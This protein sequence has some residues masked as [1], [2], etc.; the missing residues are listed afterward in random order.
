MI[1]LRNVRKIVDQHSAIE[2]DELVVTAG[3][4]A[5]VVGPVNSGR[6][7]LFDLLTGRTRPTMGEVRVAG[8]TPATD[9]KALSRCAGILFTEDMLYARQSP[10][11]NLTFYARLYGLPR[12]RA[13]D[14]LD[15]VGLAEQAKMK[16]DKMSPGMLRRLA[17]GRAI[18]HDPAALILAEPFAQCDEMSVTMLSGAMRRLAEAGKA[19]LVVASD[20]SHLQALC[21]VIYLLDNGKIVSEVRPGEQ[22]RQEVPFKVPAR[23]ED[24]V[25]LI[26][27]A[28]ILFVEA[29]E[30][31]TT[32]HTVE[33]R[34]PTQFTLSELEERLARSGF[35]RAHRSYL[36][37]L[38]HIKEIIPYTRSSYSLRLDDP[39]GTQI[40]L[41]K[42]AAAELRDLF[43]Y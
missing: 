3:E 2:I 32:L 16:L 29:E 9:R 13:K 26:N 1:E 25:A 34:L 21:D 41:S 31:R 22:W 8:V 20:Q 39:A 43:G 11:A 40:P 18:L 30:G 42:A 24:K 23:L 19:I 17:F 5:A 12:S 14:V 28:D 15:E 7:E 27:P 37:N 38:Q 4:I 35:F 33:G 36:V 10:F 6:D